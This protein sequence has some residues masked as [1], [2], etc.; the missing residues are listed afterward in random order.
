MRAAINHEPTDRVCLDFGASGVTGMAASAVHRLRQALIP[1]PDYRVKIIEPY[2]M[3]GEIDEPLRRTLGIDVVGIYSPRNMFGFPNQEWKPFTMPDGLEVLVPK[4][5]NVT[6]DEMGNT[7]MYPEGDT[8]V[9]PCARMPRSGY[10]FDALDRQPLLDE[11]KLD[12]LDN[13]EEFEPISDEDL[14]Y[15]AREAQRLFM[16]TDCGLFLSLGTLGF[17]DIALVPALWLKHPKGIRDVEEWYVSLLL[18]KDYIRQVFERQCEI[19]LQTVERLAEAIGDTID[20][21]FVTGTDFGMQNGLLASVDSYR[22]LFKP[23]HM[24]I[25][26]RIHRL[27]NWKIFIHSCGSVYELLPEFIEAGFDIFNPVQCSARNM[28]PRRLKREFGKD[29]VFWGGGVD[30]QKTL[31]FGTPDEVYREVRERIDIFAQD[32]GFVFNS[33]HNIQAN[34]PTDNLLAMY[35]AIRDSGIR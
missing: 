33:I 29:L 30:T 10:F 6:R 25:N 14:D 26:E 23:F 22:E 2:Q 17:G 34:V 12:P 19:G 35:R 4:D 21:V 31:P 18:R 20:V 5:F 8:S 15:Y 3:L 27:T 24:R 28:E 7:F 16:T 13:C 9:P 1:D 32:S 11:A